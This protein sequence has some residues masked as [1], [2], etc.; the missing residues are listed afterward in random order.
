[1]S[2]LLTLNMEETSD[3]GLFIEYGDRVAQAM[4]WHLV[5]RSVGCL[6]KNR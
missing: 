1:M 6:D 4:F 5:N 2:R 3:L